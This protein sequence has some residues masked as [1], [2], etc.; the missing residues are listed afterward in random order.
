M[1]AGGGL[2]LLARSL[3]RASRPGLMAACSRAS[4]SASAY[5]TSKISSK[6]LDA[7]TSYLL[8]RYSK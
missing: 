5:E 8:D 4:S 1:A 7:N 2:G 6:L 3:V